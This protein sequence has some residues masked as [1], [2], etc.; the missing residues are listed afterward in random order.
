MLESLDPHESAFGVQGKRDLPV[1]LRLSQVVRRA[2]VGMKSRQ[3]KVIPFFFFFIN[4]QDTHFV[5]ARRAYS[6][7][8]KESDNKVR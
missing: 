5:C 8:Q 3:K 2:A 1:W 7:S 4:P 6:V